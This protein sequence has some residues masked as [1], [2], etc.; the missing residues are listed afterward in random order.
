LP[1]LFEEIGFKNVQV[2]AIAVSMAIDDSRNGYD[3]KL[4]MV[5]AERQQM[6][7]LIELSLRINNGL[8]DKELVEL[9]QLIDSRFDKRISFIKE[10]ISVWDYTILMMQIVSGMV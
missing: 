2:D 4:A 8:T 5:E 3:E 1:K 9:R 10:G 7:E 6:F